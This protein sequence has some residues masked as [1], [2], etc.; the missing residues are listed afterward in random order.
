MSFLRL[1]RFA[2]SRIAVICIQ[3]KK[4]AK[5]ATNTH[6]TRKACAKECDAVVAAVCGGIT[7]INF[8]I[9]DN[10]SCVVCTWCDWFADKKV[11]LVVVIIV[12]GVG[13][14]PPF[15]CIS[16]V[17]LVLLSVIVVV[18]VVYSVQKCL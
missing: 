10:V 15:D 13:A 8:V 11:V 1:E 7:C 4:N 17:S 5:R 12:V 9:G 16:I 3:L 2:F 6:T 14:S 18:D